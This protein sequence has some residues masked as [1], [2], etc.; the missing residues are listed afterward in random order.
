M[1]V[2]LLILVTSSS[3]VYADVK[4]GFLDFNLYPYL[5]DVDD[6]ASMTLNMGAV[7]NNGFSYFSLTNISN[8]SGSD[9]LEDVTGF[10]TEQ[11]I[12]WQINSQLPLDLTAQFNFR[13]G[14]DNDRHRLGVRW[15]LHDTQIL[16]PFF[17]RLNLIY[18]INAHIVQ[19]DHMDGS[20]WQLEHA[21]RLTVPQ[22]SERFYLAGFIDHTFN[23]RLPN[24]I[25]NNPVVAEV[26]LGWQ[27]I[28]SFYIT[29]EYRIN[30]YRRVDVN[31][32]AV[33]VE[34]L[35]KW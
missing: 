9:E 30:Q 6:D 4:S 2:I 33:G 13:S 10:Y 22:L 29:T 11:N 26:Q 16:R 25:P 34:Y 14:E 35:M 27:L 15:R 31:N 5:S 23:E 21:F 20:A 7:L 17:Q 12:R 24:N 19:L 18:S 32:V 8:Q 3:F 1:T 28:D